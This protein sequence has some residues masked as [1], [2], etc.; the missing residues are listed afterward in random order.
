MGNGRVN[1]VDGPSSPFCM[2]GDVHGDVNNVWDCPDS[3]GGG[4]VGGQGLRTKPTAVSRLFFSSANVGA[5][6]DG[7]RYRVYVDTEG[8]TVIGRQSDT[9][10]G[11]I[12]RSIYLE[13]ADNTD[14]DVLEQVRFLNSHTI[15]FCV[16][17]IIQEVSMFRQYKKD[18]STLPTP[19]DRGQIASMKGSRTL[20]MRS[21]M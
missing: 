14:T 11:V 21:V 12:M 16:P 10:L 4:A 2:H 3:V 18:V 9:E 17:R 7:I 13:W 20:E 5:L 8:K 6:Q 1:N 19:M 15:D